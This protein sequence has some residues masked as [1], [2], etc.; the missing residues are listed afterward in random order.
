MKGVWI[1]HTAEVAGLGTRQ[2][3]YRDG[4]IWPLAV[5]ESRAGDVAESLRERAEIE[6]HVSTKLLPGLEVYGLKWFMVHAGVPGPVGAPVPVVEV[7]EHTCDT[8]KHED[9]AAD[10]YPCD[11]CA[12]IYDDGWEPKDD[13]RKDGVE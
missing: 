5:V 8:C 10:M 4:G 9:Q 3:V 12:T 2:G 13:G 6:K 7:D 11:D 1:V